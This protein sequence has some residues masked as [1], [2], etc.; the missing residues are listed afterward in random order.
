MTPSGQLARVVHF[1]EGIPADAGDLR[2]LAQP[3][4]LVEPVPNCLAPG[5]VCPH[6]AATPSVVQWKRGRKSPAFLALAATRLAGRQ[7]PRLRPPESAIGP[8]DQARPSAS[9]RMLPRRRSGNGSTI[10]SR[11]RRR[12]SRRRQRRDARGMSSH[13]ISNQTIGFIFRTRDVPPEL[14]PPRHRQPPR[15][16]NMSMAGSGTS[17]TRKPTSYCLV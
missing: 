8:T 6:C 13:Q 17:T 16:N 7:R 2:Y 3:P 14:S 9:R 10:R 12:A 15:T 1:Q 5:Q 4:A 11:G